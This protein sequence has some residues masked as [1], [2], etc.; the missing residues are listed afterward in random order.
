MMY[1][2]RIHHLAQEFLQFF[3][4]SLNNV[5]ELGNKI[6]KLWAQEVDRGNVFS[7]SQI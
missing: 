1:H 2:S 5:K 3:H 7:M 4:S 6:M